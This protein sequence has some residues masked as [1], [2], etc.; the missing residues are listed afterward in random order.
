[1]RGLK[2]L[3]IFPF[4]LFS[5]I[6]L[7][8]I[9]PVY[10]SQGL[11]IIVTTEKQ[12]YYPGETVLIYGNLTFNETLVT[13]GLVGLQVQD[14]RD[15][16]LIIRTLITGTDP[17]I[18]PYVRVSRV[19]PCDSSGN[20]KETFKT[21]TLAY[22]K[23]YV[24][25]HDI[26]PRQAL[27]TVNTYDPNNI[28]FGSAS[29]KT[30]LSAQTSSIFIVSIPIPEDVT[31]GNATAYANAYTD[32]PQLEGTPHCTEVSTTFQITNET[33]SQSATA[34]PK[35][36]A[37]TTPQVNGNYNTTLQ[38]P[39]QATTGNYTMYVASDYQSERIFNNTTFR[40]IPLGDFDGDGAV[41]SDD[42]KTFLRAWID[43]WFYPPL[44]PEYEVC[45]FDGDGKMTSDDVKAFLRAWIDYWF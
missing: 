37:V 31:T 3:S 36:Q 30:T 7:T 44:D 19:I 32:W 2:S 22:F 10:T 42:V 24:I 28:P 9:L 25:N 17:P 45:D 14:P 11:S 15:G 41:D 21:G 27:L 26:E 43:Y 40:V 6:I 20:P 4:F 16:L 38:L 5:T 18:A 34:A 29:I 12:A 35:S 39:P 33:S 8:I 13:D 23:I 1:M